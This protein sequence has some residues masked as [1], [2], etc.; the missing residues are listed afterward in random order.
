MATLLLSAN[1]A[2]QT[3]T[4]QNY[5]RSLVGSKFGYGVILLIILIVLLQLTELAFKPLAKRKSALARF[6]KG[7]LKVFFIITISFRI[8]ALIPGFETFSGQV[9]MSSSLI[10]VVLG[11][12]F[13][14]GLSN[15]VHGFI[16]SV[17]QPFHIGDRITVTIDGE[18]ITG[19]VLEINARHTVIENVLNA[20]HVIVPNSKLDTSVI[21]NN[22]F[23]GNRTSSSFIDVDVTYES[24]LEKA[25]QI[26]V[27]TINAHPLVKKAD[28]TQSAAVNAQAGVFVRELGDNGISVR[29]S[30]LTDTVEENFRACSDIRRELVRKFAEDPDVSFAYPH[31]E[32]VS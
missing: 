14:E 27:D 6:I 12:V 21:G 11:F 26:L 15:I 2:P 32:V 29:A 10:V 5:L 19:Y 9:L 23:D 31:V 24:D 16:L 18:K 8:I 7:C 3:E 25:I 30:V 28:E 20:A 17:F 1:T 13:Q 22:Y 4:S